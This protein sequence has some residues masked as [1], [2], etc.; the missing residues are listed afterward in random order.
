MAPPPPPSSCCSQTNKRKQKPTSKRKT[1]NVFQLLPFVAMPRLLLLLLFYCCFFFFHAPLPSHA[2]TGT[3]GINYGR[4]AD[5]IPSPESVVTLLKACKIKN[6]KIFDFDHS[7]LSAFKNSGLELM[8]AI[9]NEYVKDMSANPSKAMDWVNENVQPFLPDTH[10]RA[11]TVGNEILGGGD[12]DLS[13]AL[14]GAVKNVYNALKS[15]NLENLIEVSTPHS[16]AVFANSYPPSSCVFNPTVVVYMKPLLDFFASIGSPFYINVYPFLA[17]KFDPEHIDVNYALFKKNPG[18]YD[19]KTNLH[20]DN[21]FD[22]QLDAA[23]AALDSANYS[24]MEVRVS[25]TGWASS[26]DP[27]EPGA[28]V[29]NARTY[30][31]NLM[32]RLYKRKGTPMRPKMVVKAYIF[33]LFNEDSKPG[34]SSERHFGLFKADGS[35]AYDIGFKGLRSSSAGSERSISFKDIIRGDGRSISYITTVISCIT[36]L[37]ATLLTT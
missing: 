23:Y 10:I 20:Y 14:L 25:E 28:T 27:D 3:Y 4:I 29:E 5:N 11:V 13:E 19:A 36:L 32:K 31:F 37:L 30:N 1:K 21:M 8:I 26:G 24:G 7:V 35:I 2:F 22:A 34:P 15:L 16:E 33:A 12:Q 6:V 9:P 18:I 17:Y